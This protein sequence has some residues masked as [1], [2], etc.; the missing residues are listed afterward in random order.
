[1]IDNRSDSFDK[2]DTELIIKLCDRKFGIGA[3][4]LILIENHPECDFE[5]VY[6][7]SDASQSLCG[8]GS[9]CAVDFAHKLG[10]ISEQTL[11]MA[12][13]GFHEAHI[14]GNLIHLKM[15]DVHQI[16]QTGADLFINTGSPHHIR[17]VPDIAQIDVYHEG[18]KIRYSDAY[19]NGGTNV[20]FVTLL[21][22]NTIAIRTYERGVEAETLSCGTG[23]VAVSLA[24]ATKK[25]TSPV[26][27]KTMGGEL[28]VSFKKIDDHNYEDIYL[29]GPAELVFTGSFKVKY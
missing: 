20:N 4:G 9:R 27:L 10:I 14:S 23:A 2:R 12:I 17:F 7:N 1:M 5:M 3:D 22:D 11:F 15:T 24:A 19:S 25:F 13:D 28:Q 29:I 8:N 16:S 26:K 6:Y 18:Q 21:E